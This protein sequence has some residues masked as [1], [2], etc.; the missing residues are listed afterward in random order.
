MQPV[1]RF[2]STYQLN[3][4]YKWKGFFDELFNIFI[5]SKTLTGLLNTGHRNVGTEPAL[6]LSGYVY[7]YLYWYAYLKKGMY[8]V[9]E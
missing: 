8:I 2:P 5:Y 9:Y 1:S 6:I 4:W 3:I 7:G